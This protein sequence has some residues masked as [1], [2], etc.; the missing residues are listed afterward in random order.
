MALSRRNLDI[1]SINQSTHFGWKYRFRKHQ[2][3]GGNWN[4]G[5]GRDVSK[6]L[7]S[8]KRKRGHDDE[9]RNTNIKMKTK[10]IHKSNQ[11]MAREQ[12]KTIVR[13]CYFIICRLEIWE[14]HGWMAL[15][16][17]VMLLWRCHL[18][19]QSSK[20]LMGLEELLPRWLTYMT[21]VGSFCSS[22]PSGSLHRGETHHVVAQF[23]QSDGT[24]ARPTG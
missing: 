17:S 1:W 21:V 16:L 2:H 5:N 10:K 24:M 18:R 22:S 19:L 11:D 7:Y 14:R 6:A 13:F 4:H 9:L 12:A 20:S 15:G 3:N 23:P 8:W